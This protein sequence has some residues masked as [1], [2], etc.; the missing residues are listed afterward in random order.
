MK[1]TIII[2]KF[3]TEE[4]CQDCQINYDPNQCSVSHEILQL[5]DCGGTTALRYVK[6]IEEEE[7]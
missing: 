2:E 1:R 3:D 5:F 7:Q 4:G 6:C